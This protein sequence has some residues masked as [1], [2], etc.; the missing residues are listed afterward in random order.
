[1]GN[2]MDKKR[3]GK[4]KQ[5]ASALGLQFNNIDYLNEA[6]THSSYTNEHN[7]CLCNERLEFLGDAVLDV[8][9]SD[10]LFHDKKLDEGKLTKYR[11][12]FVREASL[13][14]YARALHLGDVLRLGRGMQNDVGIAMLADTF[15]ALVAAIYKDGGMESASKFVLSLM[16]KDMDEAFNVGVEE[17]YKSCLQEK[18]Q[19]NGE[20]NIN[21]ELMERTGP[22]HAPIFK[23]QVSV[24]GKVLGEGTGTTIRGAEQEAAKNALEKR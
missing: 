14:K 23:V 21:Y 1:M 12:H 7:H 6:L 4:L 22:A 17:N 9:V 19:E 10:Y 2:N 15:E 18:L 11:S 20:V 16:A 13:V 3:A 8:I 5:F 24:D